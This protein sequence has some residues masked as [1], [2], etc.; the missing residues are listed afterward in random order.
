MFICMFY[1]SCYI[2][3]YIYIYVFG[4][5]PIDALWHWRGIGEAPTRP[6]TRQTA[7]AVQSRRK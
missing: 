6:P 1:L 3:T 4:G 2:D 5:A 7:W